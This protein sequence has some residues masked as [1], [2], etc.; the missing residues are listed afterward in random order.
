MFE[1]F[2]SEIKHLRQAIEDNS[3]ILFVGAG[4]SV[5][6]GL[7]NW[8]QLIELFRQELGLDTEDEKDPLKIAQYYFDNWGKHAYYQKLLD[9]FSKQMEPNDIH[10]LIF[11]MQ[12]KHIITT[13]L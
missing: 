11:N 3:L 6:S 8:S 2:T 5:D 7:P 4:I 10:D 13:N 12:P 9:I 1:N